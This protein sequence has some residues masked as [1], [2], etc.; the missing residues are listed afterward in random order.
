MTYR[1]SIGKNPRFFQIFEKLGLSDCTPTKAPTERCHTVT[2]R[3]LAAT[4][5]CLAATERCLAVTERCRAAT[6][7]CHAAT[8]RCHAATER[9]H[10]ATERCFERSMRGVSEPGILEFSENF[11]FCCDFANIRSCPIF[12]LLK[13]PSFLARHAA[14]REHFLRRFFY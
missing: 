13:L 14:V 4:E 11:G 3:C 12:D 5:R 9:C 1:N 10:V 7:R 2:E 6:E 8:E